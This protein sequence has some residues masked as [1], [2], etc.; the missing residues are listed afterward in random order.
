M[1]FVIVARNHAQGKLWLNT[2]RATDQ[3]FNEDFPNQ[4]DVL[5]A[6][7]PEAVRGLQ[8]STGIFLPDWEAGTKDPKGFLQI[9]F[10][11]SQGK[12]PTIRK[13]LKEYD[14]FPDRTYYIQRAA[15]QLS[16]EI[17]KEVMKKAMN[18]P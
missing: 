6:T 18:K 3:S 15:K 13:M 11:A 2:K 7:S 4:N 14:E 9:L 8:V 17:D 5:I 16:D 10:Y 1:K 12:N